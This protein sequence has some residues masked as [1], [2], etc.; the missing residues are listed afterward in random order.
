MLSANGSEQ[1]GGHHSTPSR[2]QALGSRT[3]RRCFGAPFRPPG[4]AWVAMSHSTPT[5][6]SPTTLYLYTTLGAPGN[7][8][9][10]LSKMDLHARRDLGH[11]QAFGSK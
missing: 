10:L 11:R 5:S 4:K 9:S 8:Q 3:L 1:R 2:A 7:K 6:T